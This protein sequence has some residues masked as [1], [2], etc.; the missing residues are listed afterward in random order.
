[1]SNSILSTSTSTSNPSIFLKEP[2]LFI[3]SIN[4]A[5]Q[6]EDIITA[7]QDCLRARLNINRDLSKW[8]ETHGYVEFEKIENAEKAYATLHNFKFNQYNCSLKLSHSPDPSADPKPNARLR[9]IKFLP[10]TI[11]SSKLFNLFRPFGPIFKISLNYNFTSNGLPFFSGTAII[12]FYNEHQAALAQS[13]MH[14]SEIQGQT[15]VVEEYDDKRDKSGKAMATFNSSHASNWAQATPFVPN[16]IINSKLIHPSQ[17]SDQNPQ[18]SKWANS[19]IHHQDGYIQNL[20]SSPISPGPPPSSSIHSNFTSPNTPQTVPNFNSD[21]F[22]PSP[23]KQIDPCNLF[24]KSLGPDVDSGDLFHAF[25]QFG[26]IVSARVMKN[27][28]TGISKQF[29]FV[30]FTTEE[31]TSKALKAMDGTTIGKSSNRIVVRLHELKKFKEGRTKIISVSSPLG[32]QAD[33]TNDQPSFGV[34]LLS[35]GSP[36]LSR[37]GSIDARLE[38]HRLDSNS[39][40]RPIQ[41]QLTSGPIEAIAVSDGSPTRSQ[42]SLQA[43]PVSPARAACVSPTPSLAPLSERE[44][45][46]TAVLKLNDHSIGQRLD[47]LIEL[48]MS[49]PTKEKKMCLFNP[50]ILA[51]KVCEAKEIIETPDEVHGITSNQTTQ[52]TQLSSTNATLTQKIEPSQSSS[53]PIPPETSLSVTSNQ[54]SLPASSVISNV[55]SETNHSSSIPSKSTREHIN[56]NQ[57]YQFL[58]VEELAKLTSKEI[59]EICFNKPNLVKKEILPEKID[60]GIKEETDEWINKLSNLT[61][62]QQKQKVGEKVFKTLRGFGFK[63]CP[64]ITVELLDTEDLRSLS[65]LMNLFPEVLRAKVSMKL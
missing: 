10:S 59:V 9:L 33:S 63:G 61:L 31:A 51:T 38:S 11:T 7:L 54:K 36:I 1:M 56:D 32:S 17:T 15:I 4:A 20:N 16:S 12:E 57:T 24:I 53:T 21:P 2:K 3:T 37:S 42:L 14:C 35:S 55:G 19:Q 49:L 41:T 48:L 28:I 40:P 27:E 65:H 5:V 52:L 39:L 64:K 29:G 6:D 44:K 60:L 13:E 18:V 50:Q 26:T 47:E 30:S 45:M 58:T 34:N 46:L 23:Q 22:S 43:Q 8:T 25:K 62:H